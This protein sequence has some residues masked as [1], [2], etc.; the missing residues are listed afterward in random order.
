MNHLILDLEYRNDLIKKLKYNLPVSVIDFFLSDFNDLKTK[1]YGETISPIIGF[2][3]EMEMIPVFN[4][5]QNNE[6]LKNSIHDNFLTLFS[7]DIFLLTK[8]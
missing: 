7:L 2:I 5:E 8:F 6:N 1:S 3:D 4:S